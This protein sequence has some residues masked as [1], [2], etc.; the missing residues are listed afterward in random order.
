MP[1]RLLNTRPLTAKRAGS[2]VRQHS[3]TTVQDYSHELVKIVSA[4]PWFMDALRAAASLRLGTWCIGAGAIRNLVWDHLHSHAQPSSLSDVDFAYFD[5]ND[6]R[7]DA[8]KSIQ[9]TLQGIA[10]NVPWEVTNQA[11]VHLWFEGCFGHKVEPL[12]SL[13]EAIASWPEYATC[14]GVALGDRG[15]IQIIAPWGLGDL[16]GITVRRNPTR[17]SLE[18]YRQRVEQKRYTQRWPMAK[19]V[20]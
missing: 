15:E 18:T 17:V 14:V 20:L 2:Y 3:Q 11:A 6:L 5:K 16:F 10:P 19:V 4:S 1:K 13:E 7:P 8:E 9:S 12:R